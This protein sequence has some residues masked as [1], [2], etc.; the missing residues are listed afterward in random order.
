M[1]GTGFITLSQLVE[2]LKFLDLGFVDLFGQ[3]V[4]LLL[5]FKLF[6]YVLN[7][8][9]TVPVQFFIPSKLILHRIGISLF[10]F[11]FELF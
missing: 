11:I 7:L 4:F 2:P 10:V 3:L 8:L 5:N 1:N 9:Q 6:A